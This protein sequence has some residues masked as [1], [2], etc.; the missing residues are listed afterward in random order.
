MSNIE[1]RRATIADAALIAQIS[2]RT[3]VETYAQFNTPEN[4][5]LFME[6][7]FAEQKLADQVLDTRHI[8]LLASDGDIPAGYIFLKQDDNNTDAIEVARLY[9]CAG[10]IG[11]GVGRSLM[12]AAVGI[13][14]ELGK[15]K[16]WLGVWEHNQRAI[17][18]YHRA[19]FVR[20]GQQS[21]LLGKDLQND[22]VMERPVA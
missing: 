4:M 19:G 8:F 1:L 14:K 12:D 11:K 17:R 15:K 7:Q 16:I 10:F 2:R 18:F 6:Q 21:F 5:E 3:F 22:W 13:A 9:V 20:T